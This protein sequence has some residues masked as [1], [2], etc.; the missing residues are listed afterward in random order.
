MNCIIQGHNYIHEVQT[1][2]QVFFPNEG[3]NLVDEICNEG[4]TVISNA[5]DDI[6]MA[7][8]YFNG[9]CVSD[10]WIINQDYV[11]YKASVKIVLFLALKEVCGINPPWGALTGIRPTKIVHQLFAFCFDDKQII[12]HLKK[13]YHISNEKAQLCLQVAH[14]ETAIICNNKPSDYSLYIGIPFCPTQCHYC[15]FTSY[16]ISKYLHKVDDYLACLFKE[17]ESCADYISSHTA[18]TI[19]IGGG[20]P[21]VLNNQQLDL[22]LSQIKKHVPMTDI[23]EFTVEAG[24]PDSI[25]IEKLEILKEN[26]V[27][28]ISINPQTLNDETLEKI[29]RKHTTADFYK[30]FDLARATGHSNINVDLI[31][32]L[33]GENIQ[34]VEKTMEG[35]L[36]LKPESITIHTLAIKRASI[37]KEKYNL[38]DLLSNIDEMLST[39]YRF[40]DDCGYQP[41][42]LYRQKN[43]LGNFENVGFCLNG[44][45]G[46]YNVQIMEEKQSILALGAGA[47]TKT[48]NFETNLIK[49]S[50]NV[51]NVDE[52][53]NRIDE[54]LERKKIFLNK[55]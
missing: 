31:I 18:K 17:M 49:R 13:V 35:I 12:D 28:R 24:R 33:P 41:Y 23:L 36:K 4:Y 45:E 22:L 46:V 44:Y 20:T 14:K 21:T 55:L 11:S 27:S 32:G 3:F 6:S 40:I 25:T 52:Y 8:I 19:Y 5:N 54:M 15:S 42:Y 1:I 29:G 10:M 51:K 30:A 47:I 16:P 2:V 26:G 34:H 39:A 9:D 38:S 43:S 37:I 7:Q 50:E 48:V 53:I